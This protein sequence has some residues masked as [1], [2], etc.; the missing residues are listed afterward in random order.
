MTDFWI[1]AA[2]GTQARI[3]SGEGPMA[4]TEEIECFVNAEGRL[5]ERK[6]VSDRPGRF[7]DEGHGYSAD[8]SHWKDESL[9]AFADAIS[10]YLEKAHAEHR[11]ERMSIIASPKLLG[12][13]RK[14]L[15]DHVHDV[16]LEEIDKDVVNQSPDEIQSHLTRLAA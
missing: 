14:S 6:L 9:E 4:P 15:P 7:R 10:D 13:L 8:E 3:F 5:A 11:F 2:N 16:V 12:I 1:L